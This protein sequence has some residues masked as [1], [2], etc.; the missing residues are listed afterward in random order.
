MGYPKNY[1]SIMVSQETHQ[2]I[3]SLKKQ[4]NEINVDSVINRLLDLEELYNIPSETFEYELM[5]KAHKSKLFRVTFSD[6]IDIE[7]WNSNDFKFVKDIKAWFTGY[8]I[9]QTDLDAFI[10]FIIKDSNLA[11]LYE[12]DEEIVLNG[13]WIKR[14]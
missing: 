9:P 10:K 3:H 2:R 4:Y 14:V 12:M 8:K 7:Y 13:V 6:K 5:L 11:L 1:K